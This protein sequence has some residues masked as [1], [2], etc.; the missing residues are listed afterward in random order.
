M[1]YL[2]KRR[3]DTD[4]LKYGCPFLYKKIQWKGVL[5]KRYEENQ[6]LYRNMERGKSAICYQ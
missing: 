6:E 5:V 4:S 2:I 3:T 1:K